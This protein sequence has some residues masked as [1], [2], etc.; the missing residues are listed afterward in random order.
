MLEKMASRDPPES[1][2]SLPPS[3]LRW[4]LIGGSCHVT[5]CWPE[6]HGGRVADPRGPI[7]KLIVLVT[8]REGRGADGELDGHNSLRFGTLIPTLRV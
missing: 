1:P 8:G 7:V 3:K 2:V 6:T 5:C 4:L